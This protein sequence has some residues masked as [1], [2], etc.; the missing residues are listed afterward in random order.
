[1]V[2][3]VL[4]LIAATVFVASLLFLAVAY[5]TSGGGSFGVN[6]S[7]RAFAIWLGLIIAAG[8]TFVWRRW[9]RAQ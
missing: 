5:A 8:G 3:Y 1:M 4:G 9:G 7:V 6:V 2:L